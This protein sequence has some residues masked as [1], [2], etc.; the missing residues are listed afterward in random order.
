MVRTRRKTTDLL[1]VTDN[2]SHIQLQVTDNLSH[3][4]LERDSS[5]NGEGRCDL[6]PN[7]LGHGGPH[8][9]GINLYNNVLEISYVAIN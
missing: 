1:Q 4:Q 9:S 3:I 2:L 8:T 7:T 5:L 6:Q